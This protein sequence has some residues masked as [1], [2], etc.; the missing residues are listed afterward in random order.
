MPSV[1][2]KQTEGEGDKEEEEEVFS[3]RSGKTIGCG[4]MWLARR[5]LAGWLLLLPVCGI[6]QAF[7]KKDKTAITVV[8]GGRTGSSLVFVLLKS[9]AFL[10]QR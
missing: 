7:V 2:V 9:L 10:W 4:I 8:S 1:V 6:V 3:R 5:W